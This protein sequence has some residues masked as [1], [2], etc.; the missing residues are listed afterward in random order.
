MKK[1]IT[2][3]LAA[4][5]TL[6]LLTGCGCTRRDAGMDTG[7]A[8]EMTILPTNIPETTAPVETTPSTV[9]TEP[10]VVTEPP[11]TTPADGEPGSITA[12]GSYT[13]ALKRMDTENEEK[14]FFELFVQ[15]MRL[16][17]MRR[18]KDM[19]AWSEQVSDMGREGQKRFLEYCQRLVRE[20]FMY[21]FKR[22]ELIYETTEEAA[23]STNFARFVNEKNVISI[24]EELSLCQ[25]DIEQNVNP[26]M[27]FFDF[28]LKMIV[29]LIQ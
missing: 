16:S 11:A 5:L 28:A 26:R 3:T 17:Y 29:L 10:T 18:I 14:M 13:A 24:M 27:V 20:N 8:T 4:V 22:Q 15:L 1:F 2:L 19:R 7:I 25:R 21:N 12:Q 9:A 23:F 6:S